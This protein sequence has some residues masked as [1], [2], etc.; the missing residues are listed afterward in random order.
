[1]RRED[2]WQIKGG[3]EKDLCSVIC[4]E[5]PGCSFQHVVGTYV[6]IRIEMHMY[7]YCLEIKN[8]AIFYICFDLGSLWMSSDNTKNL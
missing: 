6:T 5:Q 8:S 4:N 2:V 7:K 1:M 3:V